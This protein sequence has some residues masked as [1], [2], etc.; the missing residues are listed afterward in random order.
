ML[1]KQSVNIVLE[2]LKYPTTSEQVY[3]ALCK[4]EGAKEKEKLAMRG[5]DDIEGNRLISDEEVYKNL[6]I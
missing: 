2:N 5:F 4:A 6:G 1:D 3:E